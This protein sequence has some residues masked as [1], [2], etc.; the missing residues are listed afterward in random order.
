[1]NFNRILW[2]LRDSHYML[3]GK[4]RR[5]CRSM[6]PNKPVHIVAQCP[7]CGENLIK[8]PDGHYDFLCPICKKGY[9]EL[10]LL[11]NLGSKPSDNIVF[12]IEPS[13]WVNIIQ[14]ADN[15]QDNSEEKDNED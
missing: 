14:N 11:K 8:D 12:D 10:D 13:F 7:I 15:I 3:L 4:L 6:I 1:M 5:L 9:H 2:R